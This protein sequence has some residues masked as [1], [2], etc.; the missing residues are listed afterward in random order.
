MLFPQRSGLRFTTRW[1]PTCPVR[2][3]EVMATR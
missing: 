3:G 1:E 2:M